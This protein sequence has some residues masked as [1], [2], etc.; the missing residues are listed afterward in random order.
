MTREGRERHK[1]H[2]GMIA[3]NSD[4]NREGG[5]GGRENEAR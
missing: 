2:R 3:R 1:R 5:G 4:K